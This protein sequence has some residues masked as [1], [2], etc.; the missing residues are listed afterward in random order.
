MGTPHETSDQEVLQEHPMITE[1]LAEVQGIEDNLHW[2]VQFH[3]LMHQQCPLEIPVQYERLFLHA[4]A[5]K[6]EIKHDHRRGTPK[7][8]R[9]RVPHQRV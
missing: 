9:R 2:V 6:E 8:R 5:R 3:T 4:P 1:L 7:S